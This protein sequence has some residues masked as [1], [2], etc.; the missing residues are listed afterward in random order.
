MNIIK[1]LAVLGAAAL[2]AGSLAAC[3]DG[4]TPSSGGAPASNPGDASISAERVEKMGAEPQKVSVLVPGYDGTDET[5]YYTKAIKSFEQQ[6]GKTVEILQAV[7]EQLWN[8]KVAAQIAAK[9]PIDV[10]VI[11][12]DQYLSMYQKN[13][14][15]PVNEYVDLTRKGHNIQVMDDFVKFDG[16]Y[17]AAGVSAT[18]YVLYYNRD[19]MTANGYDPDE[20]MKRYEAGTW[21]WQSFVEIARE[22][23]DT[24]SGIVGLENMF[25]EVFQASNACSAVSFADGKYALNIKTSAM[26]NT[27]EMVQDIFNKNV[28]C[29]NGYVTGQNKFL[30]GK[31]AMHGAY[32]Y[33]E[34]TFASMKKKGDVN[35]DFGVAPFP[36][37]PDNTDKRNFGHST[38]YAISMG[39]DAPYSAGVL[40]DMILAAA[41]EGDAERQA[42]LQE[43]SQELYDNLAKNLFIPSYTDGILDRGFG[44]F[45]L[46]YDARNGEDINQKL[47]QYETS[48]QKMVDDANAQLK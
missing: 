11:S 13:Y 14:L 43:G 25:D 5:S 9:D 36:A 34:S 44:A 28:V 39:S 18:P 17:Y 21:T 1:R 16:K 12:V 47:A 48:Y 23:T 10:F 33:E 45:Y 42:L 30:K 20:P 24:D 19:I 46:L 27:L 3:K 7:G 35:I 26:R 6:Y 32:A 2:V 8:E 31:A 37:G 41:G 4:D 38:G 15:T 29:G 22:C 40:I